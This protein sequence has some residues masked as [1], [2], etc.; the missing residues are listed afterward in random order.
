VG[1]STIDPVE[2]VAVIVGGCEYEFDKTEDMAGVD[3][4]HPAEAEAMA[5]VDEYWI[6]ETYDMVGADVY[7]VVV[8]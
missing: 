8:T 2:A 3:E 7:E 4:D 5:G 6:A 1:V